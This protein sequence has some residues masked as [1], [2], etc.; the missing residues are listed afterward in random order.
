MRKCIKNVRPPKM[1]KTHA[2]VYIMRMFEHA[3]FHRS[4]SHVHCDVFLWTASLFRAQKVKAA[5][6]APSSTSLASFVPGCLSNATTVKSGTVLISST[7]ITSLAYHSLLALRVSALFCTGKTSKQY[8]SST[9]QKLYTD[10]PTKLYKTAASQTRRLSTTSSSIPRPQ[11]IP[12]KTKS[13]PPFVLYHSAKLHENRTRPQSPLVSDPL[14]VYS[15]NTATH[16]NSIRHRLLCYLPSLFLFGRKPNTETIPNTYKK[17]SQ[18]SK[19]TH[20]HTHPTQTQP[21]PIAFHH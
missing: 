6:T 14:F 21:R 12:F 16:N 20:T 10:S 3:V 17:T 7:R 1:S 11:R 13:N 2:C 5:N 4:P 18:L 19:R 9:F 8:V 15:Y